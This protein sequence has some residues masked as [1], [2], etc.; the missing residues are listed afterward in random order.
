M[1]KSIID[2]KMYHNNLNNKLYKIL[3]SNSYNKQ[4][5]KLFNKKYKINIHK[6]MKKLRINN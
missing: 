2:S 3:L 5:K 1:M 4:I 6:K